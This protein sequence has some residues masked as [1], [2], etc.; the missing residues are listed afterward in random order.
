MTSNNTPT[1]WDEACRDVTE[2]ADLFFTRTSDVYDLGKIQE[3]VYRLVQGCTAA[4]LSHGTVSQTSGRCLQRGAVMNYQDNSG[5]EQ[6]DPGIVERKAGTS[7]LAINSLV[8]E[9]VD[10]CRVPLG[11][12]GESRYH[13]LRSG[14]F[15]QVVAGA[16]EHALVARPDACPGWKYVSEMASRVEKLT[17]KILDH[18][19]T[20][21][22]LLSHNELKTAE[23]KNPVEAR[24]LR[25]TKI[26]R[27][28][29]YREQH[30]FTEEEYPDVR[31]HPY[32]K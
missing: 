2:V 17:F 14:L 5:P 26:A 24:S 18:K 4:T 8:Q 1:N 19:I 31:E 13:G 7:F 15:L 3:N 6:L 23:W 16:V 9:L 20:E 25:E 10:E 21:L 28:R 30:G 22:H 29:A 12:V 32:L 27:R 11:A